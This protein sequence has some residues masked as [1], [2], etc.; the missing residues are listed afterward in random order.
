[1]MTVATTS[2]CPARSRERCSIRSPGSRTGF[3]SSL[4]TVSFQLRLGL[5][6]FPAMAFDFNSE[7]FTDMELKI[8]IG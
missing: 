5:A 3:E 2:G 7:P 1:M 8:Y 6:D 4:R